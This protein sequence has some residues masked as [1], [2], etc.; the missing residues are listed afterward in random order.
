VRL[1]ARRDY[2]RAELAQRLLARGADRAVV[3]RALDDLARLG[4]LSD[5]RFAR[6]V[7]TQKT[8]RFAK[9]AIA[10]ELRE[11]GVDST[12]ASEALAALDGHDEVADATALWRRR[13]GVAPRDEREKARHVRFLLSRGYSAS[14][15]FKVLRAAG[16][17]AED[18]AD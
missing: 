7:V 13:F 3:A 8:G 4:Y 1:L 10:Y 9:R 6:A 5:S 2:P 15:A 16:A 11:K 18:D 14:V 17:V 12:A